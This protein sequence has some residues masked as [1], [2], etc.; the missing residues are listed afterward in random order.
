RLTADE[1]HAVLREVPKAYRTQVNDVLLAALGRV[2]GDWTGNPPVVDLEGHGREE[3][4]DGVDL[5][6]TVGWFTSMF[7]VALDVPDG[8]GAALKAVKEQ[9][10]AVPRRGIGYGA[11][12]YLAGSAPVIEPQVSFNYLGQFDVPGDLT[13]H[14]ELA[15]DVAPDAVRPHL[16]EV[17]GRVEGGELELAWHYAEGVHDKSTVDRLATAMAEALREIVR[18][19]AEPGAGGRTPSDFPLAGLDQSTV[20]DLV[21]DGRDVEDIYPLTPMQAGMVFHDLAQPDD[22][23]Y[24]EQVSFTVDDVPDPRRLGEA[25][26]RVVERTPILRSRVV[27]DGVP[28]PLQIVHRQVDL[29]V[30]YLDWSTVDVEKALANQLEQDLAEGFDLAKAPLA[31]LVIARESATKV[32]VLWTFHHVLL[33]GWSVFGILSDV[34]ALLRGEEPPA[35]PPFRDY[36]AWLAAQDEERAEEHWRTELAGAMPTPLPLERP[37][38]RTHTSSSTGRI[39]V[40]L[41]D[42]TSTAV[43]AFARRHRLTVNTVVQGAWAALLARYSG[44]TEVC[45]GAT[46]S[47]RPAEL[48]RADDIPGIFINTLPVRVRLDGTRGVAEWL[49]DLQAAQAESRRFGHVGLTKLQAWSGGG[50]LFDSIVVFE[51]YPIDE[52][53]Q[54]RDVRAA[55]RTSYPL[56]VVAYPGRRLSMILTHDPARIGDTAAARL[57]EHLEALVRGMIAAPHKPVSRVPMLSEAEVQQLLAE[58]NETARPLPAETVPELFEAQVR[59]TPDAV[60]LVTDEEQITYRELDVRANRLAHRLLAAG[61]RAE[62]RVAVLMNRSPE[63]VVA[64]LAI[65]KAG[66]AYLPLDLR[67]PTERLRLLLDEADVTVLIADAT[68]LATAEEVHTGTIITGESSASDTP[69]AVRVDPEQLAYVIYTS[70]STGRPKGV[71]ARHCDVVALTIDQRFARHDRILLHSQQAFD[72]A[73]YELWVP[74]LNGGTVVL[75]PPGDVDVETL[76]RSLTTHGVTGA[77]LTT[78]LFRLVAQESPEVFAGV[79]EVWTGGDAVPAAALRRVQAACPD[80]LVADVYGP[81]ETTTFATVH[82]LPGEVPDVVPIGGPLDHTRVYVLDDDLRLAPPGAPG[83][84]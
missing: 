13:L 48:P 62:D 73:T 60:A 19:C 67:A 79:R 53:S 65:V 56:G 80:T 12:R 29:P 31:R 75:A 82:P 2:L 77:F 7:P 68:W 43:Y 38:V 39:P 69:P 36:A 74:L 51:N 18:H 14:R 32:R 59:R 26:R 83:E 4:F 52:V 9:L 63:L 25:W 61:V 78:G 57:A 20:D 44:E 21:G 37:A 42:E 10:R 58:R 71:S 5:S 47:G 33:D 17:V 6:R 27:W 40:E 54:L 64:E 30:S 28:Q 15:L 35:R 50:S 1:T 49:R 76:G 16:L 22:R 46:V 55:E 3:L 72:A 41:D 34:V 11:L 66:G 81:T 8:W 45:F 23:V 84:L 70:G 24:F